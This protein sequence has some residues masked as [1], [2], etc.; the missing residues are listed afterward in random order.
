[1][2]ELVLGEALT[3]LGK[4]WTGEGPKGAGPTVLAQAGNFLGL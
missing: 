3:A 2:D 1:M 4:E